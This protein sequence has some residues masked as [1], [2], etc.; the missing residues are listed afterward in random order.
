MTCDEFERVL[1][2]LEGDHNFEQEEHLRT[3]TACSDLVS[4][5]NVIAQQAR[6]L[7]TATEEPSP[8]VWDSIE[9]GLRQ[10]GLIHQPQVERA[11]LSGPRPRWRP[12]WLVPALAGFLVVLGVFLF[13]RGGSQ[14]PIARRP[15]VTA[16]LV[17]ASLPSGQGFALVPD[18]QQLLSLVAARTPSLQT[19]FESDL[20]AVDTY[21]RDAEQSARSHPNDEIA[22]QYLMN[23]YEQRAMVYEMALD[24]SLQ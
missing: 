10:E 7:R 22:Q 8:R 1:P 9:I 11:S 18:E 20:R 4:D 17:S 24:R 3:C 14:P 6:L 21:I 16:P 13:E 2:E 23:A 12:L 15:L 5:L 19:A